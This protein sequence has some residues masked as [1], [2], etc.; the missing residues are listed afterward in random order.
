MKPQPTRS[1]QRILRLLK[2]LNRAISAQDLYV[3]LRK[4]GKGIGLATVYRSL[5]TLKLKGLVQMRTLPSG[6]SLYSSVQ[7][8]QHH[9]TCLD[10]GESIPIN[11]CP[12]HQLEAELQTTHQFKI[13]YH[14]LEFFGLCDRC[15][16]LRSCTK[17]KIGW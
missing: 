14:T 9:L 7:K 17:S 11:E 6:E 16:V 15:V 13:F 12:V 8:D 2:K 1:Q 10:C 5:E 4:G 3:E